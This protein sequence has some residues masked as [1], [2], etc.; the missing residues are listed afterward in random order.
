MEEAQQRCRNF[1]ETYVAAV[2]EN[3]EE[4]LVKEYLNNSAAYKAMMKSNNVSPGK[5]LFNEHV[6]FWFCPNEFGA[7]GTVRDQYRPAKLRQDPFKRLLRIVLQST[8]D[9]MMPNQCFLA[10]SGGREIRGQ[11]VAAFTDASGSKLRVKERKI[12]FHMNGESLEDRQCE[13]YA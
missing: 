1:R 12:T 10:S 2:L 3:D 13:A 8:A 7:R 11:L 5:P 6:T 9:E 4:K